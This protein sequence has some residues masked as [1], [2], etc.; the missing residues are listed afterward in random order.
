MT[1]QKYGVQAELMLVIRLMTA[2][3]PSLD[4]MM[5]RSWN[6]PERGWENRATPARDLGE[7]LGRRFVVRASA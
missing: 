5:A 3:A 7:D 6:S 4:H 1:I 2:A